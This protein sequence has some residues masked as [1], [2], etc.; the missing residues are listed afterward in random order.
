MTVLTPR[1]HRRV[2]KSSA[3]SGAVFDGDGPVLQVHPHR[4]LAAE[5]VQG[6]LQKL[7]IG[8]GGGAQNYPGHPGV[9]ILLDGVQAADAP[10]DLHFQ[11]GFLTDGGNHREVGGGAVLGPLQVHGVEPLGPGGLEVRRLGCRVVR[12]SR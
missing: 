12:S 9:Q 7:W 5:A 10:A 11:V 4:R 1:P 2:K 6:A 3:R 8:D